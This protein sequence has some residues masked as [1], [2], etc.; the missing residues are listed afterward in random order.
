MSDATLTIDL[1]A[2][3]ANWRALDTLSAST[4]ETGAVVKADAY[5]LGAATVAPALAK[6][7][8]RTFYVALTSE[9]VALRKI[10]GPDVR[11]HIFAGYMK[12][13]K[14]AME[15][16]NLIPLL[17]SPERTGRY[18]GTPIPTPKAQPHAHHQPSGLFR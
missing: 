15:A 4:V 13:D 1:S 14:E 17:N 12:G 8:A 16:A 9:G 11:I 18:P 2:I 3:A 5:G 6:A 7:G 10:L